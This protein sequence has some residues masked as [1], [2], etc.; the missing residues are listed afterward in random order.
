M[1]VSARLDTI[2]SQVALSH[3]NITRKN[4]LRELIGE[5]VEHE[6]SGFLMNLGLIPASTRGTITLPDEILSEALKNFRD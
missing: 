5:S 1:Q 2:L 4:L 6:V 3:G